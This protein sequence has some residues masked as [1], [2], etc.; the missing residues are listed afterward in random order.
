MVILLSMVLIS[1]AAGL[2]LERGTEGYKEKYGVVWPE[3]PVVASVMQAIK[4]GDLP[5]KTGLADAASG[6]GDQGQV[7][8]EE[9]EGSSDGTGTGKPEGSSDGTGTGKPEGSSDGTGEGKSE[10]PSEENADTPEPRQFTEV[11]QAYF[12]DALFIGDSRT[13]GL[14]EYGGW[15]NATYYASVGLT[16]YDMF[17]SQIAEVNGKKITVEEALQTQQFGKI[18]LMIGINEMGTGNIDSFMAAYEKA[19]D[20]LRELQPDALI[21][22][23][24]IMYVRK[25]KSDADKIFNNR[26][27]RNRNRRIEKLANGQDIFYLEVNDA[28]D[29]GEGNLNPDYTWDQLHLLGKYYSLWT[30]YLLEHGI[31]G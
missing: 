26:R 27:I 2:G 15:D 10:G 14:M 17:D 28:V 12:D 5:W 21:F 7:P 6:S 3:T 30:D 29:D 13:V 23:E 1:G 9:P 11:D 4:A 24:G 25:D 16:V 31:M 18:Y 19:L 20:H 22:L 8:G